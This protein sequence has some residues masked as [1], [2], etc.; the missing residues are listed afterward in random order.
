MTDSTQG[1]Y[2]KYRVERTDGKSAPG[3]KHAGCRYFV[4]DVDHDIF[5]AAALEAYARACRREYPKLAH[6]I[7]QMLHPEVDFGPA[8]QSRLWTRA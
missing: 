8:P 7:L 2:V 6:N 5:A 3:E 4:L 1:L